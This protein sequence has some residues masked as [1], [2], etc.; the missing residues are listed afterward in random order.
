MFSYDILFERTALPAPARKAFFDVKDS[1]KPVIDDIRSIFFNGGSVEGNVREIAGYTGENIDIIWLAVCV[2]LS[3]TTYRIYKDRGIDENIFYD[4]MSDIAIWV[5]VSD[6]DWGTWGLHNEFGWLSNHLRATLFR[7]GR[8]QFERRTFRCDEYKKDGHTVHRGDPVMNIHI[9][10]GDSLTREK[11][12]DSYRRAHEFF[13]LDVFTCDT[14]L[15]YPRHVEFLQPGSN[16]LGFMS[17]FDIIESS[18]EVGNYSNMWRIFGHR[19]SYNP[20]DLPRDTGMRRAYADWLAK[21][22]KTGSGYGVRFY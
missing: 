16:I 7:L 21:E 5:K 19:D 15:F 14:W 10:E 9:P 20:T 1:I 6:R 12:F 11:R 8:L 4:T 22:N 18:E 13:G 2:M 3:E 17:D